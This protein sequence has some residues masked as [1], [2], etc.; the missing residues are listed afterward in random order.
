MNRHVDF[1]VEKLAIFKYV[2]VWYNRN[3]IHSIGY[4]SHQYCENLAK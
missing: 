1:N 4:M 3:R 2:E